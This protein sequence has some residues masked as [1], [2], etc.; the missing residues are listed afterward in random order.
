M[1]GNPECKSPKHPVH[2]CALKDAGLISQ[3]C[4][5]FTELTDNPKFRCEICGATA[6][7]AENLCSPRRM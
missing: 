1:V 6:Q 5:E 3:S 7:N 2:I 4:K